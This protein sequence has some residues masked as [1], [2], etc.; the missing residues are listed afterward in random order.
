MN[1]L[2]LQKQESGRVLSPRASASALKDPA[3]ARLP[4]LN[5]STSP[6]LTGPLIALF[7]PYGKFLVEASQ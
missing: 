5:S 3:I 7:F 1:E 2:A 6:G 4:L